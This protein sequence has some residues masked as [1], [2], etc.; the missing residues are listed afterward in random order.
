MPRI[1][2]AEAFVFRAPIAVPV[3]NAF[4][5]L[6]ERVALIL[7][8]TDQDGAEGWGE[9]WGNFPSFGVMHRAT[10]FDTLV[11]PRLLAA[12]I[13]HPRE[14]WQA[15]DGRLHVW[16][17]QAG[18][19]GAFSAVLAG[20]DL[21]LHDL[22]ARRAG[23]PLWRWLGGT[24]AAPLPCY[25]SGLNPDAQALAQVEK[26][27]AAGYRAFKVKLGFGTERDLATLRPVFATLQ[28]GERVMVDINQGW[29]F[30]AAVRGVQA[31]REFPLGW[32]EEPL[33]CDRPAWEWAA[34]RAA[35]AAPVA[36]GENLRGA[37]AFH[38]AL[39]DG[40]LDVVQP[41]C[42]KWGGHSGTLPVAQAVVGAGRMYCPHFLGGAVGLVHSLHL[43]AAVR[44]PKGQEGLLEWD[45]NPN[46]LRERLLEGLLPLRD[47]MV[48]PPDGPGLGFT[49]ALG[50]IAE[51]R[52]L[53]LD[54]TA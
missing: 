54:R 42:A 15:E 9:V 31:L 47:G 43:L 12:P 32:I 4:G 44:G 1:A 48:A 40:Q 10:L 6:T 11:A 41:D 36:A 52:A 49:P 50:R 8:L 34:V 30:A 7:K 29:D 39:A 2:R 17:L 28:A 18:E 19:P 24:E 23:L 20:V 46:P 14:F 35:A 37:L 22:F 5:A 45:V 27:R 51:F 13:A 26:A 3:V 38:Q 53:H 33:T 25:A 21:A 16:A